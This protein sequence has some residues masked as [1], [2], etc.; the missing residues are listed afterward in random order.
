MPADDDISASR[1]RL[2]RIALGIPQKEAAIACGVGWRTMQRVEL[3]EPSTPDIRNKIRDEWER[4]GIVFIKEDA[5]GWGIRTPVHHGPITG[6]ALKALR[7]GMNLSAEQAAGLAHVS[8]RKLNLLESDADEDYTSP[9]T[10][11][12]VMDAYVGAGVKFLMPAK[13]GGWGFRIPEK[14]SPERGE[15]ILIRP[16]RKTA[17]KTASTAEKKAKPARRT[18]KAKPAAK[19]KG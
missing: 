3:G 12:K 8:L 9:T 7:T 2:A 15:V 4:R 1:L 18:A 10:L 14:L 17:Q 6:D 11:E 19:S 16:R 5:S 13:S